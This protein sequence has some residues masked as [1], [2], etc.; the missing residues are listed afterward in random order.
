M[1]LFDLFH[2]PNSQTFSHQSLEQ[3]AKSFKIFSQFHPELIPIIPNLAFYPQPLKKCLFP[4][5]IERQLPE[6]YVYGVFGYG[7]KSIPMG[8][9]LQ[10][11]QAKILFNNVPDLG[12]FFI[13]VD[14]MLG[15]FGV[16][17][18]FSHDTVF[19]LVHAQEC[20]VWFP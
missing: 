7:C 8:S 1:L 13:P 3:Q 12:Y 9:V 14:L 15:Q 19:S 6:L 11:A 10:M 16:Y 4:F 20:S 18:I 17:L 2:Y 5:Y